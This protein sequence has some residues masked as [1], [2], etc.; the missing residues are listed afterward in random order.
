M[1]CGHEQSNDGALERFTRKRDE[2]LRQR[3]TVRV[4]EARWVNE[5]LNDFC[6]ALKRRFG[7][8][9]RS[10][11]EDIPGQNVFGERPVSLGMT[12]LLPG[13]QA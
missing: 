8:N 12:H 9:P 2:G 3:V 5:D 4:S 7:R 6:V 1:P 11:N 10:E 13:A